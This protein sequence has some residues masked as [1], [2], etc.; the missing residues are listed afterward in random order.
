MKCCLLLLTLAVTPA[1][2]QEPVRTDE[3]LNVAQFLKLL[4]DPG[5]QRWLSDSESHAAETIQPSRS[6]TSWEA[7]RRAEIENAISAMPRIPAELASTAAR[8][9]ADALSHGYAPVLPMMAGIALLGMIAEY[10][11]RRRSKGHST[12]DQLLPIGV[13]AAAMAVILLAIPWPTLG[14]IVMWSY[15]S[16][17]VAYRLAATAIGILAKNRSSRR[18]ADLIL[19]VVLFA[20]A[21]DFAGRALAVDAPIQDAISYLWSMVLLFLAVEALWAKSPARLAIRLALSLCVVFIW[22]AWCLGLTGI[23]WLGVYALVLPPTLRL[24]SHRLAAARSGWQED[25]LRRV[26]LTRGIRASIIAVAV[27]WLAFSWHADADALI[28]Q[29]PVV[30]ALL[31]VLLK[32]II[33]LLLADLVWHLAKTAIAARLTPSETA[34]GHGYDPKMMSTRLHTLLPIFKNLLAVV[35][36]VVTALTVLA[37]L[38]VEIGPLVAG[39]GIFGVA[40]GFGSQTLVKD[41]IGGVFY[42]LDDAFRVGEYIQ[43][44]NYKGTVEGFSLRSVRLR[45]H[46]GPVFTVPFGELGAVENMSRDWG[47][48]KFRISVRYETDVE[49]ARKL[50][51]KIGT[52]LLQ[53]PELGPLFIDPLKMKGI[54]EF[55]DYGMILSFGMTL[56]PSPMQ[57]FIRRRANLLLREAFIENG[58]AFATPSVQVDGDDRS[59]NLVAASSTHIQARRSKTSAEG[60]AG[61]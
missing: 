49:K 59:A 13:F 45:H 41:V 56:R 25:D 46:R 19:A 14:R 53:D 51:K 60:E 20:I 22:L 29:N 10:L 43:A 47:V 7:A 12:L 2:A 4:R 50:T 58:I 37:E 55:G 40:L 6:L 8:V 35:V 28:H 21:S 34:E 61:A 38:G 23:F 27:G 26:L 42:M 5:V 57:S 15:L 32:S 18:R 17:F 30:A 9:R 44:K 11:F 3:P 1:F 24:I 31:Y 39:A 48:V 33:V 36:I 54:E 16:A 52:D